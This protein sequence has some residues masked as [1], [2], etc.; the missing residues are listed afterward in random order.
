M[1]VSW[2][3]FECSWKTIYLFFSNTNMCCNTDSSSSNYCY[4]CFPLTFN[5]SIHLSTNVI[6][7]V[8]MLSPFSHVQ[9]FATPQT[10]AHQAPLSMGLSR[11][12]SWS[13]LP[14]PPPG[15]LPDPGIEPLSPASPALQADSSPL[16]HRGSLLLNLTVAITCVGFQTMMV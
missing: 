6:E 15:D 9:L 11:Q 1:L 5:I 4:R 12:E 16:S 7:S 14:C 13:G 8:C 2:S 10:V 3:S